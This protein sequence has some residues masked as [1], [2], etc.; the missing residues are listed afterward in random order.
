MSN[1]S[2]AKGSEYERQIANRLTEAGIPSRRVIGSGAHGRIDERLEGDI[3]I[4]TL[5]DGHWMLT[6]EVK[7]RKGGA[8]F[9][10]LDRWMGEQDVLFLRRAHAEPMVY[11]R[12]AT[13]EHLCKILY[14]QE[15]KNEM[16]D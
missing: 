8:G 3:Q 5:R 13:F 10:V 4:G 16:E 11:M 12:M 2:K 15:I 7:Y 1:R 9:A 14:E 6:G